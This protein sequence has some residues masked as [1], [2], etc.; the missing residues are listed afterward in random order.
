MPTCWFGVDRS[1]ITRAISEVRPLLAERGRTI[2]PDARLRT[3]G[4]RRR[5]SRR[6]WEAR[7]Y[8]RHR[9]PGAAVSPW[10]QGP[11]QV[12]LRQDQAERRQGHG[13]HGRRGPRALPQ[14]DP[15]G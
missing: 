8:R 2:S 9:G 7:D 4:R 15:A 11:E 14:P 6:N 13:G 5:P 1:T 12:H 3:P 10:T